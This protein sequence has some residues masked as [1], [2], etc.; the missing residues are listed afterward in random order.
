[1]D[2]I[3]VKYNRV[4][5]EL[6]KIII[7]DMKEYNE[8]IIRHNT[9]EEDYIYTLYHGYMLGV[10]YM[11]GICCDNNL[12]RWSNLKEEFGYTNIEYHKI[13]N[14]IGYGYF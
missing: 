6:N 1:M 8:E 3:K 10:D 2:T 4:M 12:E 11:D 5:T 14:H 9:K 7:R 13:L